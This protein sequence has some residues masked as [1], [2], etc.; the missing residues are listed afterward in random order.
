[1]KL[2]RW[3]VGVTAAPRREP[4]LAR[5]LSSLDAAGWPR[6]WVFA[7]GEVEIPPG[8]RVTRHLPPVGGWPNFWLAVTEL[9]AREP[10]ADAYL[11]V[12]DDV[13]FCAGVCDYVSRFDIP[14]DCGVLSLFCPACHNQGLGWF[15]IPT[16]QPPAPG[17]TPPPSQQ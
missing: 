2:H 1:M 11:L 12:Q 14:D 8:Y 13:I 16:Y 7:D 5:T 3:A 10:T 9:I 6:P 17:P 4:T 15:T